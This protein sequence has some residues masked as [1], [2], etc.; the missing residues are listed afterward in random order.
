A[1]KG[2]IHTQ[3][4]KVDLLGAVMPDYVFYKDYKLKTLTEVEQYINEKGH[5]P[6]IPS[7]KD[8][9]TNGLLLKEMNLKLLEKIEE[10]TLYTIEQEKEIEASKNEITILKNKATKLDG[11]QDELQNQKIINKNLEDKLKTQGL[12]LQKIETLLTYK[13]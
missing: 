11:L 7:A 5:L 8:V 2:D 4:V 13:H 6:N 1:V 10:L 3:E 9:E 12:R